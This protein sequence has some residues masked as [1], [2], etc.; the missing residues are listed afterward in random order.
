VLSARKLLN[1][2]HLQVSKVRPFFWS[3]VEIY[4]DRFQVYPFDVSKALFAYLELEACP[5]DEVQALMSKLERF[6]EKKKAEMA[7]VTLKP[8]PK[9]TAMKPAAIKSTTVQSGLPKST[10]SAGPSVDRV[11]LDK[12][13]EDLRACLKFASL[14]SEI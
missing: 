11:S 3:L 1:D 2:E 6:C 7:A 4:V 13:I 10:V 12:E 5:K 14:V 8:V 9:S